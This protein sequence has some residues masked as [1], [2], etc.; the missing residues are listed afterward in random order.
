MVW[1]TKRWFQTII[2]SLFVFLSFSYH[3][4]VFSRFQ[5]RCLT[6]KNKKNIISICI[7][8]IVKDTEYPLSNP[9]PNRLVLMIFYDPFPPSPYHS[10]VVVLKLQL[11]PL[12]LF[13]FF[14]FSSSIW[15][16][17][18]DPFFPKIR[19]LHVNK[20]RVHLQWNQSWQEDCDMNI[21]F[22]EVCATKCSDENSKRVNESE[23]HFT[24]ASNTNGFLMQMT[25]K[26]R[27]PVVTFLPW[28]QDKWVA[29][30]EDRRK[31]I[32]GANQVCQ[33]DLCNSFVTVFSHLHFS[34]PYDPG[35][36]DDRLLT[37]VAIYSSL[38]KSITVKRIK[39]WFSFSLPL[40]SYLTCL[41][42][43]FLASDLFLLQHQ[44]II[45]IPEVPV[46][47]VDIEVVVVVHHGTKSVSW[48]TR[49]RRGNSWEVD[50]LL[51]SMMIHTVIQ[52]M[53]VAETGSWW[54]GCCSWRRTPRKS[55]RGWRE[56][57]K[58]I[59][60]SRVLPEG[61]HPMNYPLITSLIFLHDVSRGQ[62]TRRPGNHR[63]FSF[64]PL[65]QGYFS[66]SV[67]NDIQDEMTGIII[68]NKWLRSS[69]G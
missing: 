33:E 27:S 36:D 62:E 25:I 58:W 11:F 57:G 63:I 16:S 69:Q 64:T 9:F 5:F 34:S 55:S 7:S 38:M 32:K 54:R 28:C 2:Q 42:D 15:S 45:W 53:T 20:L 51:M 47:S 24:E 66:C 31:E 60:R 35:D 37:R 50:V 18:S 46:V 40:T 14:E 10:L 12:Q 56:G 52:V 67:N 68:I 23:A 59:R 19:G 3:F 21:A 8:L 30:W 22:F 1:M 4:P 13:S 26:W 65:L 44:G 41:S 49:E 17:F 29:C 39:Q 48:K 6:Q 61:R 43:N